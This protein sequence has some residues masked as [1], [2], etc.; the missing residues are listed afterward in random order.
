MAPITLAPRRR[1][2]QFIASSKQKFR[3]LTA[4]QFPDDSFAGLVATRTIHIALWRIQLSLNRQVRFVSSKL[5]GISLRLR[6]QQD[7]ISQPSSPSASSVMKARNLPPEKHKMRCD[8]ALRHGK[9]LTSQGFFGDAARELSSACRRAVDLYASQQDVTDLS[10]ATALKSA[11]VLGD[12][13]VAK[14]ILAS[15]TTSNFDEDRDLRQ[16]CELWSLSVQP[17][18]PTDL[19]VG[20]GPLRMQPGELSPRDTINIFQTVSA[21]LELAKPYEA[22]FSSGRRIGVLSNETTTWLLTS[23][24]H[25]ISHLFSRFSRILLKESNIDRFCEA[26]EIL[27][28]AHSEVQIERADPPRRIFVVGEPNLIQVAVWSILSSGSR[29]IYL[30]GADFWTSPRLHRD[31]SLPRVSLGL[32]NSL[33]PSYQPSP[34]RFF[35]DMA[36]HNPFVNFAFVKNL[37]DAN[38]VVVPEEV[39]DILTLDVQGY[40]HLLDDIHG[41]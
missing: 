18:T 22:E 3:S 2:R 24:Q 36:A 39:R 34:R 25:V 41:R 1:I 31:N 8:R 4:K 5:R 37:A 38:L 40:G 27:Q 6:H 15:L 7:R 11:I 20:A 30:D 28:R 35:C 19:I 26:K 17:S 9:F 33:R 16:F 12:L 21:G 10:A 13:E 14:T 23:D 29:R 32:T